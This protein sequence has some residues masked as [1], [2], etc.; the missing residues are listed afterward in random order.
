VELA[1]RG[2]VIMG[3]KKPRVQEALAALHG[4]HADIAKLPVQQVIVQALAV[5][6]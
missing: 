3:F 4:R 2:L 6:T 1:A 5:L